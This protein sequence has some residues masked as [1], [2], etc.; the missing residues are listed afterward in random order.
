VEQQKGSSRQEAAVGA[1]VHRQ[2]CEN[3]FMLVVLIMNVTAAVTELETSLA[4]LQG[5]TNITFPGCM[6][7]QS[8]TAQP[9]LI[10]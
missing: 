5:V 3:S 7:Q 4:I 9:S 8:Q 2:L 1:E 10:D 6:L